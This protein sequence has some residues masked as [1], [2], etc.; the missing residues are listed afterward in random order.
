MTRKD[1]EFHIAVVRLLEDGSIIR[2]LPDGRTQLLTP[3]VEY[4][5]LDATTEADI[6]R[7]EAEDDT[8]V[9]IITG[10]YIRLER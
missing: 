8:D 2:L 7:Q 6:A 9:A 3:K 10:Q 1:G 5:K 4:A